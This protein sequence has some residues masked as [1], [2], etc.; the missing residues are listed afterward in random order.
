[1]TD[2]LERTYQIIDRAREQY[3]STMICWSGGKD[4]MVLLHLLRSVG[5]T[6][7]LIFFREPWQPVKYSFQERIIREWNLLVHTWH[8]FA[9]AMQQVETETEVQNWYKFNDTT[10]TCPTGIVEPEK[11]LPWACGVDILRRPKQDDLVIDRVDALWIGHKRCDSDPILGGDAGTRIEARVLPDMTTMI[12]PIKDWS[13]QDVWQYIEQ[14]QVPYDEDR[15][16]KFD[17][18]WREIPAKRKNADY[19]HACTKCL[20]GRKNAPKFVECPKLDMV[21]EN[22]SDRVPWT[23]QKKPSYMED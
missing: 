16:E 19:V 23:S 22:I 14:N 21:I 1:M 2:K 12:Y 10:L 9:S 13:H 6:P 8:P 18:D 15:Y 3:P 7:P 5:I 4:S 17:G 20:D 11:D